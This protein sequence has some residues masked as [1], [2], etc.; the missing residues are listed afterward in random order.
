MGAPITCG[1]PIKPT[2]SAL[3][4]VS[5][6]VAASMSTLPIPTPARPATFNFFAASKTSAVSGVPDRV[7]TAS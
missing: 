4:Q 2:A 3:A 6:R 5:R 1:R 7:I